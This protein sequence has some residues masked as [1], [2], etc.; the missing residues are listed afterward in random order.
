MSTAESAEYWA[1]R[2][3]QHEREAWL[4]YGRGRTAV[5]ARWRKAAWFARKKAERE[6]HRRRAETR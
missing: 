1:K 4:S 6:L 2:A 5:A 3:E